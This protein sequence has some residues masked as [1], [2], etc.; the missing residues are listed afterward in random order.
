[1]AIKLTTSWQL[2]AEGSSKVTSNCTGY[3]RLYMKYAPVN[4]TQDRI[5][6]EIRQTAYNPYGRYLGWEWTG[7]YNWSIKSG[8]TTRA[9]GSHTQTPAIYSTDTKPENTINDSDY[10][11][12]RVGNTDDKGDKYY[13]VSRN[14]DGTYSDTITFSAPVYQTIV[15]VKDI[16]IELPPYYTLTV[17]GNLDGSISSD[18]SSHGTFTISLNGGAHS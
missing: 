15:T 6:Y 18:T 5:Y 17:N 3:T 2:V 12:L 16:A 1:M 9:S 10:E 13:T 7:N 11:T 4:S 14:S 8:S